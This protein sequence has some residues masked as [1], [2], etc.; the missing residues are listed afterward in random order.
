MK[1]SLAID[2]NPTTFSENEGNGILIPAYEPALSVEAM[3]RDDPSLLQLKSWLLQ[4]NVINSQDV[5]LLDK[6]QIFNTSLRAYKEGLT[7]GYNF[8]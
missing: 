6:S 1:N 5:T 8:Q 7:T 3:S 4:P 2:D